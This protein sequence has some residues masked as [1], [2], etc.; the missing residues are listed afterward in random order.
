MN[1]N[2]QHE[3]KLFEHLALQPEESEDAP[4]P[5]PSRLK[6][7]VYSALVRKQQE[8]GA[9]LSLGETRA[10]EHPLCV[11]EDLWQRATSGEAAQRFN[12]CSLCHARVL[13]ERLEHA[14]IYWGNCPYVA[15]GKK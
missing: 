7:R 15:F 14:P 2:P 3:D 13:A 1:D 4:A 10:A 12:C 8:T 9:L 5:A 6:S 11:F